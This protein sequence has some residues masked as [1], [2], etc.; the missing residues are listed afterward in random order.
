MHVDF[1]GLFVSVLDKVSDEMI[2]SANGELEKYIDGIVQGGLARKIAVPSRA[3]DGEEYIN[4]LHGTQAKNIKTAQECSVYRGN[5]A[6]G[7]R[8]VEASR[9][10]NIHNTQ[11]DFE[12]LRALGIGSCPSMRGAE[13][14]WGGSSPA[15]ID[16]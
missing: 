6:N 1:P 8:L 12:S 7:G 16:M 5:N 4:F 13:G 9:G 14:Y 3:S 2:F 11:A 15:N 10:R